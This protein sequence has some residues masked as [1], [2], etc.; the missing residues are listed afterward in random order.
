MNDFVTQVL[1]SLFSTLIIFLVSKLKYL[2]KKTRRAIFVFIFFFFTTV[3]FISI[4]KILVSIDF[5]LQ[6][7]IYIFL[8]ML[9]IFNITYL[10]NLVFKD[11]FNN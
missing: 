9:S 8:L 5:S 4:I 1:A 6:Y 7:V 3:Q 10:L 11:F 2:S